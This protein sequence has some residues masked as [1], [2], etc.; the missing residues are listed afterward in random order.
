MELISCY[1]HIGASRLDLNDHVTLHMLQDAK[2]RAYDVILL[3]RFEVFP[4]CSPA[5]IPPVRLFSVTEDRMIEIGESDAP[6]LVEEPKHPPAVAV[7][8][9]YDRDN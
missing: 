1:L 6:F 9:R 3:E 4:K 8:T 2:R 5:D 7:Y